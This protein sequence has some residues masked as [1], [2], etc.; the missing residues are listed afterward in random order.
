MNIRIVDR[1]SAFVNLWLASG[2]NCAKGQRHQSILITQQKSR[3]RRVIHRRRVADFELVCLDNDAS[4]RP[5]QTEKNK[6]A[7]GGSLFLFI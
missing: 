5:K 6:F 3:S 2:K 1:N 7:G 4:K